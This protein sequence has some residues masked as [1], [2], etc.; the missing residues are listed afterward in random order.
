M[1]ADWLWAQ[2]F[3]FGLLLLLP[4][5]I[6]FLR[7]P[8]QRQRTGLRHSG[9]LWAARLLREPH[10]WPQRLPD[11][12]RLLACI[13]LILCLAR[14]QT[15]YR[16]A[17]RE[18]ETLDMV[19]A[20]DLSES[21]RAS[22]LAPNRL[23]VAK[24][25]LSDFLRQRPQDR[26]GLVVFSGTALLATP[27]TVDHEAVLQSLGEVNTSTTPVE[28]TAIG[29]AVLASAN[30]LLAASTG[31]PL[32]SGGR[33]IVLATDG[34]NNQGFH[35]L[36]AARAAAQKGI[37]LYTIGIGSQ[38]PVPRYERDGNPLRDI[39]GRRQYWDQLDE[40]LLREM[41]AAGGGKYFRAGDQQE[42]TRVLDEINRLEK[43]KV[44][45]KR[46]RQVEE[47]YAGFLLI[48]GVLL[49]SESLLRVTRFRIWW[50]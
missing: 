26:L 17:E 46:H 24:K 40:P 37:R 35:P 45:I 49:F 10:Q 28:G 5:V 2:P 39:Y 50:G 9:A 21:M 27:L 32:Q 4:L 29:D 47:R 33:V 22:D 25:A 38:H 1:N 31:V 16:S 8:R 34:A 48:A 19:L 15:E 30:R 44:A 6:L 36:I 7:R 42:L 43:N 41:A 14:P 11:L 3:A 23:A 20:L 18:E 12:L 13:A